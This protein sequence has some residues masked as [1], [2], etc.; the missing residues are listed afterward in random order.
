MVESLKLTLAASA[1]MDNI[2][3]SEEEEELVAEDPTYSPEAIKQKWQRFLEKKNR[4]SERKKAAL[5]SASQPT[6]KFKGIL[7]HIRRSNA[8]FLLWGSIGL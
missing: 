2:E 5:H 4:E 1:Q 7:S 3:V 8:M 6:I